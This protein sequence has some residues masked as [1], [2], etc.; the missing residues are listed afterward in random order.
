MTAP[1]V[2][3]RLTTPVW[4]AFRRHSHNLLAIGY[5]EALPRILTEPDEETDIRRFCAS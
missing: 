1:R 2:S 4:A 5:R 3:P